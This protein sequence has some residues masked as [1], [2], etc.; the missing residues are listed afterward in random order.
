MGIL[1]LLLALSVLVAHSGP[2]FGFQAVGG[3]IAVQAFFMISGFYMAL[4]LSGK[5]GPGTYGLFISNRLLR[6][7]PVYWVV[8]A[9]TLGVSFTLLAL[10]ALPPKLADW[11][12]FGPALGW[13]GSLALVWANLFILGQDVLLF[14]GLNPST[15]RFFFTPDFLHT[16]PQLWNL[17]FVH[18]A[19]SLSL[20]IMFYLLAPALMRCRTLPLAVLLLCSVGLRVALVQQGFAS[21]PWSYRFF[22]TEWRSFWPGPSPTEPTDG[23]HSSLCPSGCPFWPWPGWWASPW[24]TAGCRA[25]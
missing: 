3:E 23:F 24:P 1:R 8:L 13:S 9:L 25:G 20:E 14:L 10:G 22:P 18:Q 16:Q 7:F 12:A 6:L 17:L 15:G 11:Q 2:L 4:V 21:D 5:Y 19:W